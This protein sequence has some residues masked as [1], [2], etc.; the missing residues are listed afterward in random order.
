MHT[1]HSLLLLL[2]FVYMHRV[3]NN[4]VHD[5]A[6][7]SSRNYIWQSLSL[8][9]S[10]VG[11]DD[12]GLWNGHLKDVPMLFYKSKFL[13]LDIF[14]TGVVLSCVYIHVSAKFSAKKISLLFLFTAAT[15]PCRFISKKPVNFKT[16]ACLSSFRSTTAYS[17]SR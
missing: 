7:C 12:N 13:I 6:F 4:R 16:V 8:L 9:Y 5:L 2:L 1:G 3:I 10:L 15:L 11:K 14:V 17:K